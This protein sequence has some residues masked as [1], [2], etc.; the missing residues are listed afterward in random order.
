MPNAKILTCVRN[1]KLILCLA[2]ELW[3]AAAG[4]PAGILVLNSGYQVTFASAVRFLYKQQT[5]NSKQQTV[6]EAASDLPKGTAQ[7]PLTQHY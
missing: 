5:A 2:R 3:A 7:L 6:R 1:L 4:A